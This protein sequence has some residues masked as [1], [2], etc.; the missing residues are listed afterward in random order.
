M[1]K[2]LSFLAKHDKRL[3]IKTNHMYQI[4]LANKTFSG[5]CFFTTAMAKGGRS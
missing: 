1:I 5:A 4:L 2:I 3:K